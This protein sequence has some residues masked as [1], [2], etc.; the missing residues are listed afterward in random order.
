MVAEAAMSMRVGIQGADHRR[1]SSCASVSA[2]YTTRNASSM[3]EEL[4]RRADELR[5]GAGVPWNEVKRR[6]MTE[7]AGK[8]RARR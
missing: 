8:A 6:T 3:T 5:A 4:Q 1:V 7:T 2:S